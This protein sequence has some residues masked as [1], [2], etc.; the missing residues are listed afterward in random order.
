[1]AKRHITILM[2]EEQAEMLA[3]MAAEAGESLAA[4]VRQR[5]FARDAIEAELQALQSTLL[6]AITEAVRVP[7]TSETTSLAEGKGDPRIVGLLMETVL[8][9]RGMNP[10]TKVQTVHAEMKRRGVAPVT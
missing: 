5:I 6:A 1:M 4:F 10:P 7:R 8:L 9:L 2:A 3:Q